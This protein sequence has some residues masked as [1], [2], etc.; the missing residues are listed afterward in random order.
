MA[1][2]SIPSDGSRRGT[3]GNVRPFRALGLL[4]LGVFAGFFAA[5]RVLQYALPSRGDAESD[6]V[7]LVAIFDGVNVKSHAS[8]FRGGTMLSWFGGI[9]VDLREAQLAEDARLSL[10]SVVGGIAI[11]IPPGWRVESVDAAPGGARLQATLD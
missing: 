10:H 11:R 7:A 1:S 3:L 4:V 2:A 6:E 8:A 5:A 9:A